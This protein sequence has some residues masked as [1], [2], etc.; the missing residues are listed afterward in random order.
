MTE[1]TADERLEAIA[2][3]CLDLLDER[4]KPGSEGG[5]YSAPGEV[6]A[7]GEAL[8]ALADGIDCCK[9]AL[10]KPK[11]RTTTDTPV[12]VVVGGKLM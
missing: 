4:L 3:R 7:I 9:K 5:Q 12:Q 6:K 8:K 11:K 10:A 2:N 1:L